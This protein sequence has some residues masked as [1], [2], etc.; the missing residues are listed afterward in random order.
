MLSFIKH[1]DETELL[2][3]LDVNKSYLIV[4]LDLKQ[5]KPFSC[6]RINAQQVANGRRRNSDKCLAWSTPATTDHL[7]QIDPYAVGADRGF[8]HDFPSTLMY[9]S[10]NTLPSSTV[11]LLR[12]IWFVLSKEVSK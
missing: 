8:K 9:I 1:Y 5:H 7:S 4:S 11:D 3:T 10:N 2:S 6:S 12:L